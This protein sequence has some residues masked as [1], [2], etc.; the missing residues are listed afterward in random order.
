METAKS[1]EILVA[2]YRKDNAYL[3]RAFDRQEQYIAVLQQ[4]ITAAQ[5]ENGF[6]HMQAEIAQGQIKA[7]QSE[8]EILRR[9]K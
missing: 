5:T 1:P 3:K 4:Q 9:G 8:C 2:S 7:S 6:M